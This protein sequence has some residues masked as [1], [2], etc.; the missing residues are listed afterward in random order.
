MEIEKIPKWNKYRRNAGLNADF[1]NLERQY[2]ERIRSK[3]FKM[4]R[5]LSIVH[6]GFR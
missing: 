2:F 6:E 4:T 3:N 5:F 1:Y